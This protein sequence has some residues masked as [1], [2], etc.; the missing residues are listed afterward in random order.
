[1]GTQELFNTASSFMGPI[2]RT[3]NGSKAIYEVLWLRTDLF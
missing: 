2:W 1:M 3:W